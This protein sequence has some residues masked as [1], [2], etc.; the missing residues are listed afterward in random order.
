[1]TRALLIVVGISLTTQLTDESAWGDAE[2]MAHATNVNEAIV[3]SEPAALMAPSWVLEPSA[4]RQVRT[5][6]RTNQP[7]NPQMT[8]AGQRCPSWLLSHK[9]TYPCG[10]T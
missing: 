8:S 2:T 7:P 3:G 1:M 6:D 10:F 5:S 9:N 4:A